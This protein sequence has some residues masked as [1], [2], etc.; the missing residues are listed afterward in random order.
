MKYI[1]NTLNRLTIIKKNPLCFTFNFKDSDDKISAHFYDITTLELIKKLENSKHITK[2][3]KISKSVKYSDGKW[4]LKYTDYVPEEYPNRVLLLQISN[5]R[6]DGNLDIE[7]GIEKYITNELHQKWKNSQVKSGNIVTAI[8][9]T[10]GVSSLIPEG[11]PEANLNQALGL[12]VLKEHCTVNNEKRIINKDY[13]VT[14]LN[15]VF[16]VSQFMRYGG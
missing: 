5:L 12:I 4:E 8:T 7:T 1:E 16:A 2:I 11:F 6:N 9:A 13:V 15:S 10:I 14:Y 3:G